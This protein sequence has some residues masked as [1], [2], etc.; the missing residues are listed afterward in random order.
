MTWFWYIGRTNELLLDLDTPKS[1]YFAV[2]KLQRNIRRGFL[3]V[4]SVWFYPTLAPG[5]HHM[6]VFLKNR[7]GAIE[8]ALWELYLGS[9]IKRAEYNIQ[10]VLRGL[11][12]ADLLIVDKPYPG[13][14]RKPDYTCECPGKHKPRRITNH[15]PVLRKLHGKD[16]G[17][18]YFAI[19]RD[20]KR[21]REKLLLRYGRIPISRILKY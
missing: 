21:K 7:M 5:H 9:D 20:R 8:R 11:D 19:N 17:A 18:E 14:G 4:K 10:R 12:G 15:C 13:L 16:A 3:K 2:V 1:L 6:L